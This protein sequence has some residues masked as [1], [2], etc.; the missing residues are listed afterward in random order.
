[1]KIQSLALEGFLG[2]DKTIRIHF[3][4]D[5]NIFT[6]R[7]GS[8]KTT[9]L[10]LLWYVLS[11]NLSL[12][13][14]EIPF[15]KAEVKTSQYTC[16]LERNR[17]SGRVEV[18]HHGSGTRYLSEFLYDGEKYLLST[19]DQADTALFNMGSSLFLPT[20]RR[21][22][23]GFSIGRYRPGSEELLTDD[24]G[25]SLSAF[26]RKLSS[27][28]HSLVSSIGTHDIENLLI[29]EYA[30]R[31]EELNSLKMGYSDNFKKAIKELESYMAEFKKEF[32]KIQKRK[33]KNDTNLLVEPPSISP[34]EIKL[35]EAAKKEM[36][37]LE[38]VTEKIM[39][40]FNVIKEIVSSIMQHSGIRLGSTFTIGEAAKAIHSESLSAGEKQLFSFIAYNAFFQNA[41]ILID[42]PELSLHVDWQ[43]QLFSILG[44]QQSSN[45]FIVATHSPFIYAKYPDKETLLGMDHGDEGDH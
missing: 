4:E 43:R 35:L 33:K 26:S 3:N 24:I 41:V 31:S 45:Q 32:R 40:P 34:V 12:A 11:G 25:K 13:M 28:K 44:K 38:T 10:K 27:E 2:Q 21:I 1:M 7:N 29:K 5:I 16:T 37:E 6:G 9:L 42:E 8:G 15:K 18:L 22:E 19:K 36:E 14:N 30:A 17:P 23:G 39:Q 20:F